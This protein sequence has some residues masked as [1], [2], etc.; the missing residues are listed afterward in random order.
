MARHTR[1]LRIACF[2]A[3]VLIGAASTAH[4]TL[5]P[6][7][8][9]AFSGGEHVADFTV[10]VSQ[11]LPY[12]EDGATFASFSGLAANVLSGNN[13][14]FMT[15]TGILRVNFAAPELRA[16]FFFG[17]SL[18]M[19][20]ISVQAFSDLAGAVSLGTLGLG[21]FAVNQTGFV[22]FQ[23]D[24]PFLRA[25]V[26][27]SVASATASFRIDDFRFE[28]GA[29]AVPEPA[30]LALTLVGIGWLGRHAQRRRR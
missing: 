8:M 30:T 21:S 10:G 9:G 29:S 15:G 26:S 4:A 3:L 11:P 6:I 25:D 19:A 16:G 2:T 27:F 24:A 12:S 1:R 28:P 18:S 13:F 5:I 20:T 22:G 7:S 14:L 17:N 23:A